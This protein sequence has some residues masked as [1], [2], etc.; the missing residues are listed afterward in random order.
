MV[1]K[2][3]SVALFEVISKAR[4]SDAESGMSVPAWMTPPGKQDPRADGDKTAESARPASRSAA[5]PVV[6]TASGRLRLSLNYVSCTAIS[7]SLVVM[8]LLAFWLGRTT[9]RPAGGETQQASLTLVDDSA[10]TAAEMAPQ[11]ERIPGKYYMVIQDLQGNDQ[12]KEAEAYRI[13]DYCTANGEPAS[14]NEYQ[15]SIVV[16]SRKPFD[17]GDRQAIRSHALM[18]EKLGQGYRQQYRTY[19]FRQ[20]RQ[21]GSELDPTML[22]YNQAGR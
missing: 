1:K 7:F 4:S 14:V 19:D 8:L 21:S 15:K 13:A 12:K 2:K 3:N 16:W 6:S 11:I 18:L 22:P 17:R 10:S 5:E 9:A 20:R